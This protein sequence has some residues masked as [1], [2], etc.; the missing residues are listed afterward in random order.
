MKVL[1]NEKDALV[2]D[3]ENK[4]EELKNVNPSIIDVEDGLP[5]LLGKNVEIWCDDYIFIGKL[6]GVNGTCVKL[7]DPAIVYETGELDA[8][9]YRDVQKFSQKFKY[10]ML[11]KIVSFGEGK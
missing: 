3:I 5:V 4:L 2:K 9:T 8:K 1:T 6:I 10:L 7:Q 11:S